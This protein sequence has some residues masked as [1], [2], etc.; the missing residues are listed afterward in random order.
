MDKKASSILM[1]IF[2]VLAVSLVIYITLS[3]AHTYASSELTIKTNVAEDVRMMANTLAGI[4]GD[5]V[6]E[7]PRKVSELTIILRKDGVTVFKKGDPEHVRVDRVFFLPAGYEAFGT[8]EGK[9]RLC[10]TK[11][12]RKIVLRECTPV[13]ETEKIL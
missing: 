6:V 4:P 11:E 1:I 13:K 5:A 12:K 10:L 8:L 9:E 2:E 7:Y 3:I